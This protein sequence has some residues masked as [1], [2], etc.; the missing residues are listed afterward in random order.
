VALQACGR[1]VLKSGSYSYWSDAGFNKFLASTVGGDFYFVARGLNHVNR[2][3][4]FGLFD[5]GL[6]ASEGNCSGYKYKSQN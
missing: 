5:F 1:I 3:F 2:C 6:G 4:L